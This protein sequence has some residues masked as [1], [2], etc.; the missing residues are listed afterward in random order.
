MFLF[1]AADGLKAQVAKVEALLYSDGLPTSIEITDGFITNIIHKPAT[2]TAV[3][4]GLY[5]APGLIDNQVNGY[6]S[7]NFSSAGL[8]L[9]GIRTATRGLWKAGVTT[10]LPTLTTNTHEVL[11]ESFRALAAAQQ[12]PEIGPS[13]AGFH[14]EGPYISPEDGYR[15]AHTREW[16]RPP[17]WKEFQQLNSAAGNKI[18]EVTIAPETAGAMEFIRNCV[19]SGIIVGLGHHNGDAATIKQAA[20][21]GAAISTHLGNGCANTINRHLNPLWPQLA[22]ERLVASLIV[23]GFHLRPEQVRV[24]YRVKG[25]DRIILTS[26][27]TRL[28]GMPPGEYSYEGRRV[29]LTP[30]GMAKLPEQE[31]LAGAALPITVGIGNMMRYS[32]C[33][34]TEAINMATR[35]PA[36]LYSLRNRGEIQ[37]GK[38]ADLVLFNM[39]Q[40]KMVIRETI[41]AGKSVYKSE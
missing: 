33:S 11:L 34:L 5:V 35:N 4:P 9:D 26:D 16:V 1:F 2:A 38:R 10:Y 30:E 19:K 3:K 6:L 13:V 31:V 15:G 23:D 17:D 7:I 20:D 21:F 8:T 24:F 40:D 18:L 14:L 37:I 28:A 41:L 12:D 36:K 29:V 25:P 39:E 22:D 32:G 27:V